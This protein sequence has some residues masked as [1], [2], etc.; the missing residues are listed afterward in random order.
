MSAARL[1]ARRARKTLCTCDA[2]AW[3]SGGANAAAAAV[4]EP[5][6]ST[7]ASAASAAAMADRLSGDSRLHR[8]AAAKTA[9]Q[10]GT[11]TRRA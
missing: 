5:V 9:L 6:S 3:C 8:G 4:S 7:A 2:A 10:P 11:R 1:R